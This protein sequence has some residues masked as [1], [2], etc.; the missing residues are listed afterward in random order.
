MIY[1]WLHN[2]ISGS[3]IPIFKILFSAGLDECPLCQDVKFGTR[4]LVRNAQIAKFD[5]RENKYIYSI[6]SERD[7]VLSAL[8]FKC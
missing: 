4:E 6:Y 5:T 7:M 8:C 2:L 3:N 1:I